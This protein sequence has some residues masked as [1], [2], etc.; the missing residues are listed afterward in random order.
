MPESSEICRLAIA[1]L[2][3]IPFM[4]HP[5]INKTVGKVCSSFYWKRMASDIREFVE[6]CPICQL[7]KTDHT[8]SKGQLQSS[9]IPEAKWQEVSLDFI[10]Y[11]PRTQTEDTCILT[12]IHK[13]TRLVH[14]IPC[15][16]IVDV[17]TTAELYWVHVGKLHGIPRCIYSDRGPQFCNRFWKALWDSFG[18]R[19]KSSSAYQPQLQGM[20]ER[21]NTVIGQTL[22][23]LIHSLENEKNW[24]Q[25]LPTVKMSIN[26]LPNRSTSFSPFFLNYGYHLVGLVQLLYNSTKH[27]V[28][29]VSNFVSRIQL[30]W[31]KAR[32]NIERAQARQQKYYDARHKPES[33]EEGSYA[34][35]STLNLRMK[36]IPSKLRR[37][38][39][40]PF[41]IIQCI[42]NQVY[43][44]QLSNT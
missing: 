5:R 21:M 22:R 3:E 2:H 26:S 18:T 13:A 14:L 36:G 29:S 43:K 30:A 4:A 20:I 19:L 42:G 34:L 44:L 10:T 39:V 17:V 37:R 24:R 11:L 41:K 16:E 7:E 38:F 15:R 28:E 40:G 8:L 23:C 25:I 1:E 31:Q 12:V 33:F 9:R 27:K 35:L 32:E 6:A